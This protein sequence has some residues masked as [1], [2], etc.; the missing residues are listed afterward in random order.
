VVSATWRNLDEDVATGRFRVDLLPRLRG[1]PVILPPLRDRRCEIPMLARRFLEDIAA[2]AKQPAKSI[3]PNAMQ[4]L[5]AYHWPS[6]VR[7][8]RSA[9]EFAHV[10]APD[11]TIEPSDLRPEILGATEPVAA[12]ISA[13]R[14]AVPVDNV[15]S[16]FRALAEEVEELE[17]TRMAQALLVAEGVKTR[18]AQLIGMPVR[19]FTHK[20]RQ[21]K[22]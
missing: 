2:S 17:R 10:M 5:L 7:E 6:N 4:A 19:T 20:L 22:L 21:Y 9:M 15:P 13:E 11:S 14:P 1:A 16:T 18:A 3:S 12:P 8:L